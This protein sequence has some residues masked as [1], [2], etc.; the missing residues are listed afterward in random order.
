VNQAVETFNGDRNARLLEGVS[1]AFALTL[2]RVLDDLLDLLRTL[3]GKNAQSRL[4][5]HLQFEY[6]KRAEFRTISPLSSH[7]YTR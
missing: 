7:M 5:Y 6:S 3:K 2:N 1:I 4:L